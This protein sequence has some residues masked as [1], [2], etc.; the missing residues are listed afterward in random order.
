MERCDDRLFMH[1]C[2]SHFSFVLMLDAFMGHLLLLFLILYLPRFISY[3]SFAHSHVQTFT[4][5]ALFPS[6]FNF[7]HIP[8]SLPAIASPPLLMTSKAIHTP[9]GLLSPRRE[10]LKGSN[11]ESTLV[12]DLAI[13]GALRDPRERERKIHYKAV[14]NLF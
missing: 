12:I 4:L 10:E 6:S 3:S 13:Y 5:L 8:H 7:Q 14:R 9:W 11:V 1:L 2:A